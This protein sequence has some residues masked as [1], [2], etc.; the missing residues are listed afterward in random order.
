MPQIIL[1][2]D[3]GILVTL[4]EDGLVKKVVSGSNIS[5]LRRVKPKGIVDREIRTLQLLKDVLNVQR[6]VKRETETVFYTEYIPGDS[7]LKF[8]KYS[9]DN[10][11]F[12]DLMNITKQCQNK[13]IYRLG[14]NRRD[15]LIDSEGNPA[16]IDFGNILFDDDP[17]AKIP[18]LIFL[19]RLYINLR[20]RD[21]QR[22]YVSRN[23]N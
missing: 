11:Y 6:F 1:R 21:I 4:E 17:I 22:R 5:G 20:I 16:I 13:G 15:F 8:P 2:Q 7:L 23:G 14:Q 9:L 10:Q 12:G 19:A 18:G 3:K